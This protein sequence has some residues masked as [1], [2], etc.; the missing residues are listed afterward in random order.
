M[1][2][3]AKLFSVFVVILM[4]MASN[5]F[6]HEDQEAH[7]RSVQYQQHPN[8]TVFLNEYQ[9][10]QT[11]V[12][13]NVPRTLNNRFINYV[14]SYNLWGTGQKPEHGIVVT[15][16][17]DTTDSLIYRP[18][19]NAEGWDQ[20]FW[21]ATDTAGTEHNYT[22]N[23]F[24]NP[25]VNDFPI[26][27]ADGK[28]SYED[29][30]TKIELELE[31]ETIEISEIEFFDPDSEIDNQPVI[32][33]ETFDVN[34]ILEADTSD[35]D[36]AN[37]NF[38]LIPQATNPITVKSASKNG[39]SWKYDLKW[40]GTDGPNYDSSERLVYD[41]RI[42]YRDDQMNAADE[43]VLDFNVSIEPVN[44]PPQVV[45]ESSESHVFSEDD[46][47]RLI[48][49]LQAYDQEG[50]HFRWMLKTN[51]PNA[52]PLLTVRYLDEENN[53]TLLIPHLGSA[54]ATG[55]EFTHSV[56]SSEAVT[57][58]LDNDLSDSFGTLTYQFIPFDE[59]GEQEGEPYS[60]AVTIENDFSDE[61]SLADFR[62][63]DGYEIDSV[64]SSGD[65]FSASW[66]EN[67]VGAVID[68]Q[69]RDPD[70]DRNLTQQ[71]DNNTSGNLRGAQIFYTL[72]GDDSSFFTIDEN[73]S[74]YFRSPPNYERKLD[75]PNDS[76]ARD[77]I[78]VFD[79]FARD[80]TS[81]PSTDESFTWTKDKVTFHIEVLPLDETPYLRF[82]NV[83]SIY[84]QRSITI[85]ED[86]TWVWD[87][88]A[89]PRPANADFSLKTYEEEGQSITWRVAESD[90]NG[91]EIIPR[92]IVQI[93]PSDGVVLTEADGYNPGPLSISY[94][95]RGT[96]E[97][98]FFRL[99]FFDG[100][101]FGWV[102]FN[103]TLRDKPNAPVLNLIEF[104][105]GQGV[106]DDTSYPTNPN[107][108]LYVIEADENYPPLLTLYFADESDGHEINSTRIY[109]NYQILGEDLFSGSYVADDPSVYELTFNLDN[110]LDFDYENPPE[111]GNYSV[112]LRVVDEAGQ[113]QDYEFQFVLK[114]S[115]EA[116]LVFVDNSFDGTIKE[117][118]A[119]VAGLS[120]YDP[121]VP[122]NSGSNINWEIVSPLNKFEF[123]SS[124][125]EK[126]QLLFRED[127]LPDYE[128]VGERDWNVTLRAWETGKKLDASRL[129]TLPF[130][131]TPVNDPPRY[132][133]YLGESENAVIYLSENNFTNQ[134]MNLIRHF[135]DDENDSLTFEITPGEGDNSERFILNG[136]ILEYDVGTYG[137]PD[138]EAVDLR[139]LTVRVR[140]KDVNDFYSNEIVLNIQVVSFEESPLVFDEIGVLE[141]FHDTTGQFSQ[142]SK[143][144]ECEEDPVSP[145]SIEN[146]T[147][148]DPE[149]TNVTVTKSFSPP[150]SEDNGTLTI[151][152]PSNLQPNYRFEYQPPSNASGKF[153]IRLDVVD[154]ENSLTQ[155]TLVFEVQ[156]KPDPPFITWTAPVHVE[157]SEASG[158]LNLQ[159]QE[160]FPFVL[161]LEADDSADGILEEPTFFDWAVYNFN[162]PRFQISEVFDLLP[163]L[164]GSA[165]LSEKRLFFTETPDFGS[166]PPGGLGNIPYNFTIGVTDTTGANPQDNPELFRE[167]N[168]SIS[169]L[170]VPNETPV[171]VDLDQNNFVVPYT[172]ETNQS[173]ITL[174]AFD[175]DLEELTE[176]EEPRRIFYTL[177]GDTFGKNLNRDDFY[178]VTN[179]DF[180][181]DPVSATLYFLKQLPDFENPLQRTYSVEVRATEF[182]SLGF[183]RE[184]KDQVVVVKVVNVN[185]SP[186]FETTQ[187]SDADANFTLL[188]ETMGTFSVSAN[189][190]DAVDGLEGLDLGISGNGEDDLLFEIINSS[191]SENSLEFAFKE[192]PNFEKPLDSNLDND[193]KVNIFIKTAAGKHLLSED[194]V[195][196]VSDSVEK[197]KFVHPSLSNLSHQENEQ[198]VIRLEVEDDES[199]E[200][201]LDLLYAT[202]SGISFASNS[203]NE[204]VPYDT[205]FEYEKVRNVST[206]FGL[207]SPHFVLSKDMNN[208]GANDVIALS[209]GNGIWYF[210]NQGFGKFENSGT[211]LAGVNGLPRHAIAEDFDFDGDVDLLV[212]I[213]SEDE[214]LVYLNQFQETGTT[215]FNLQ[216]ISNDN[217]NLDQPIYL[218]SAD[219]DDDYDLD[220]A[221]VCRGSSQVV[222]YSNDG[223]AQFNFVSV[224]GQ[225][226]EEPRC[227]EVLDLTD[228]SLLS[229]RNFNCNDLAVGMK[230]GVRLFEKIENGSFYHKQDVLIDGGVSDMIV[231]SVK[232]L[233]LDSDAYTDIV[234]TTS[235]GTVPYYSIKEAQGLA[236]DPPQNFG[237]DKLNRPSQ[238]S[239]YEPNKGGRPIVLVSESAN[240]VLHLFYSPTR[241]EQD[242]VDFLHTS[243]A[244]PDDG[245]GG[246]VAMET[247]EMD[248]NSKFVE[249]TITGGNDRGYFNASKLSSSGMLFF[250]D[251]PDYESRID[252]DYENSYSVFVTATYNNDPGLS[253][254]T[255]VKIFV[256]DDPEA[257]VITSFDGNETVFVT[258]A[259]NF[260]FLAKIV[261]TNDENETL[262]ETVTFSLHGDHA[263]L[264]DINKTTGEIFF[265]SP[266]DYED[267][268][269]FGREDEQIYTLTVRA[270]DSG[271][272]PRVDEQEIVIQIVEGSELPNSTPL[273]PLTESTKEEISIDIPLTYF[274]VRDAPE[275]NPRG[276]ASAKILLNGVGG[277]AQIIYDESID[278][279]GE[280]FI[281]GSLS[282]QPD[283]DFFGSDKLEIEFFNEANL[284]IIIPFDI[285]VTP[286]PDEPKIL[287]PGRIELPE[288]E[289]LVTKLTAIDP[290]GDFLIWRTKITDDPDF[291]IVGN[292]LYF[293][294][295]P[296]YE[297]PKVRDEGF[298]VDL[299]VS[300][301]DD[302]T[303]DQEHRLAIN[304]EN[305]PDTLPSSILTPGHNLLEAV[306]G[307]IFIADLNLSDPDNLDLSRVEIVGGA[308]RNLFTIFNQRLEVDL[309]QGLDFENP[310]DED[311]NSR[312]ELEI[313]VQDSNDSELYAVTVWMRDRD[314]HPPYF[315]NWPDLQPNQTPLETILESDKNIT[316]LTGV[317]ENDT[318]VKNR[319]A[320]KYSIIGGTDASLFEVDEVDGQLMF[321]EFMNFE[322]PQ[323]FNLDGD[324]EVIVSIFDGVYEVSQQLAVRVLDANDIPYLT[325]IT[326]QWTEDILDTQSLEFADE[327][328]DE[329]GSARDDISAELF[330]YPAYGQ[331]TFSGNSFTYQ[332]DKDFYGTDKFSVA[333]SDGIGQQVEDV[334]IEVLGTNDPPVAVNDMANYYDL[335]RSNLIQ[336]N[337]LTNDHSGPD[338]P[339]E[340][341]GYTI[342]SFS[343]TANGTLTRLY[344]GVFSYLPNPGFLGEDTFEYTLNDQGEIAKGSVSLWVGKT[345]SNPTWSYLR[346]FGAF[347]NSTDA[348]KENWIYHTDLGWVYLSEPENVFSSTWM[349]RDYIGWFWTG[350]HYFKWIYSNTFQ[351]WLHWEGGLSNWFLRDQNGEI[352]DE[353]YFIEKIKEKERN[354]IRDEIIALL[355]SV[356]GV[357][358]YVRFSYF[359]DTS[360]KSSI[361]YEL[362]LSKRSPTLNGIF[363][364]TFNF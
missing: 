321:K 297:N 245:F 224:I 59:D 323:D 125:G 153:E 7:N 112:V 264:F 272:P 147:F 53:P 350:E 26:L 227:L 175:P 32:V 332:P 218:A 260:R 233:P 110:P 20:F 241:N 188:E 290:D 187:S 208:D 101:S 3:V 136:S 232:S 268:L 84:D 195:V 99:E 316:R 291:E 315:T 49:N 281:G 343:S 216:T 139:S 229:D 344:G 102:D 317:D 57:F 47:G 185:E 165:R 276:I 86:L 249:Y 132:N 236:F 198:L 196:R 345:A 288:N 191:T 78:Y 179:Y 312:Y 33:L 10:V 116:P 159:I 197:P 36:L 246:L 299:I 311:N 201:Y 254:S 220:F 362:A 295:A 104:S 109:S 126:V 129:F 64:G 42:R 239:V 172:E 174:Q 284:S 313:F 352:Y 326:Y 123:N 30:K 320:L 96:T 279:P 303:A 34:G 127:S 307:D 9:G 192:M 251:P 304:I 261:A 231:N 247:V 149:G 359:F 258:H 280:F 186:V 334:L 143:P 118:T 214:V 275:N 73:G 92:G 85:D 161:A 130:S 257:P 43:K 91:T 300:D 358:N 211:K 162:D 70:S 252:V 347:M 306:E 235:G 287:M 27:S 292:N 14:K 319:P 117:N 273:G 181:G 61:I 363:N 226:L 178:L 228:A 296:D 169:I 309:S 209:S 35:G 253:K 83:S 271:F 308:D 133:P 137:M 342:S 29:S 52:Y 354:Q 1:L 265:N 207:D 131:V 349:W 255:L 5:L 277:E 72:E 325:K 333:L 286:E 177:D 46:N 322:Y 50:D 74:I 80:A 77:N 39:K 138:Y 360:Q 230:G 2:K 167:L 142:K 180:N 95:P 339:S 135:E 17:Y 225:N 294:Y 298:L 111:E 93:E 335:S 94:D 289:R 90:Q 170:D 355:P 22:I 66:H 283:Q 176:G 114:D 146:F 48:L 328:R 76:G 144:I 356:D 184:Y 293:R 60:V 23:I 71:I 106:V 263:S 45:G 329:N 56:E 8:T 15:D 341:P 148:L 75:T 151:F 41:L 248:R 115:D 270:T 285:E 157:A 189:T 238:I 210:E 21:T 68:L 58:Y 107:K 145:V 262:D 134:S 274:L 98:D 69:T 194:F 327:D 318:K 62:S 193:Y 182:D 204:S 353:A 237:G 269:Y 221:V 6:G 119:T 340:I 240:P 81:A 120:A 158:V 54:G 244:L 336:F 278:L 217:G 259:E 11:E 100:S 222:W 44:E 67:R 302:R 12:E 361:I 203:W 28:D 206:D 103:F 79:V 301:G 121:D 348:G 89:F 305:L 212:A 140:A 199:D 38:I 19:K 25:G 13:I 205:L 24:I 124:S 219:F 190:D 324:Y 243:I 122:A 337:V 154:E 250:N 266:P 173:V 108:F 166:P 223:S 63:P 51:Q 155:L 346:Y 163:G 65:T 331:L 97:N 330:Q 338:D 31:E 242:R 183:P 164:S 314:E 16:E 215:T 160:G 113:K 141:S 256:Q 105:D 40:K 357:A 88:N 18:Y 82:P 87:R 267:P 310:I 213:A 171:F 351:K 55:G 282:Y 202:E 37:G 128:V 152:P 234:F 168:V 150:G 4:A 200:A 156:P 364:Y